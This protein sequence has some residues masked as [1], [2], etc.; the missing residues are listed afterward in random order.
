MRTRS[1]LPEVRLT[2]GLYFLLLKLALVGLLSYLKVSANEV[3]LYLFISIPKLGE[4]RVGK[5]ILFYS[6]M[7]H[8]IIR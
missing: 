3:L 7:F 1:L 4:L 2:P 8:S 6:E 5:N